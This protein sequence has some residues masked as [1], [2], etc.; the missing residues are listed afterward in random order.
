MEAQCGNLKNRGQLTGEEKE[1]IYIYH[2]WT[3]GVGGVE[4][5]LVATEWGR[6]ET[7]ILYLGRGVEVVGRTVVTL[8]SRV[9]K[10]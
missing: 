9:M 1:Y 4:G 7:N 5:N 2:V 3:R 8:K 10:K 6:R